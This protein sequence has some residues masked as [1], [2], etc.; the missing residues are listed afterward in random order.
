MH[1]T[2]GSMENGRRA[3]VDAIAPVVSA[4]SFHGLAACS[5]CLVIS[6]PVADCYSGMT[7]RAREPAIQGERGVGRLGVQ[8]VTPASPPLGRSRP[9]KAWISPFLSVATRYSSGSKSP[10]RYE[11]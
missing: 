9:Q 11:V 6:A 2:T 8:L 1:E 7:K 10:P 3:H 5:P 4:P